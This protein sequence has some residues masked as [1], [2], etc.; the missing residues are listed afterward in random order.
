MTSYYRD[1]ALLVYPSLYEGFGLPIL[2]AFRNRC[3]VV[4]SRRSCF[5]EIAGEAAA[6]FDPGKEAA[7]KTTIERVLKDDEYRR[8]LIDRGEKRRKQFS[9]RRSA[10]RL[11]RVYQDVAI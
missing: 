1:A 6:Y 8:T 9:W 10:E 4:A 7:L 5:P 2:E 11:H 3:P